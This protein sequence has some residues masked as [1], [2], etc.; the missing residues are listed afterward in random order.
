MWPHPL[1]AASIPLSA[2]TSI[3]PSPPLQLSVAANKAVMVS[4]KTE[5]PSALWR[6]QEQA[7]EFC[8]EG[9]RQLANGE[10]PLATAFYVA[11]SLLCSPMAIKKMV[12]LEKEV[13]ANM[14]ALLE[15]WCQGESPIPKLEGPLDPPPLSVATVAAFLLAFDPHNVTASLFRMEALFKA[16]HPHQVA[17]QCDSLLEVH[18]CVELLLTHAL[19][20]VLSQTH[21]Q[22][23]IAE[24]LQ[25]FVEDRNET[26]TFMSRRQRRYTEKII[27]A[28]LDCLS[29][30]D[31]DPK[32]IL[33][34]KDLCYD[35]LAAI[36]PEDLRVCHIQAKRL[37]ERRMYEECVSLSSRAL[38][39][40]SSSDEETSSLRMLRAAAFFAIGGH[41]SQM[42][43]D[44]MAAFEAHP[45]LA[46][47]SF[48]ALFSPGEAGRV[49]KDS[50]AV[51]EA[52]FSAYREAVRVRNEVRSNGGQELIPPVLRTLQFLI[53]IA[54]GSLRELNVRLADCYLLEGNVP[55][56]LEICNRLLASAEATYRNTLLAQRGLCHLHAKRHAEAL[57]D[58]QAVL[59]DG[60]PHPSSCVKALCGRGLIRAWAGQPYLT[61]LDYLTA[62]GLRFEESGF[63]IKAYVP[64]NQ[65]GFLLLVLQEQVQKMLERK[66]KVRGRSEDRLEKTGWM[67]GL[68]K[69]GDPFGIHQL[70]SLLLELD[71]S[72]EASRL[73]CADALYQLDRLEEAHKILRLAL[74]K[75]SEKSSLLAR[76][77]LFQLRKGRVPDCNQYLKKLI[78][79]GNL[80]CLQAFVKVLKEDDRVLWKSHCHT[81]AVA[82]L[83]NEPGEVYLKEAV[84]YLSLAIPAGGGKAVDSL[85]LRARC[86]GLLGQKKTAIFDF[87][88]VLKED[89]RN[90]RALCGK[91]F[92][93]LALHQKKESTQDLISALQGD[94]ASAMAEICSLKPDTQIQI[95]SW[96][97]EYCKDALMDLGRSQDPL[98]AETLKDL[99]KVGE[100]LV[101]MDNQ[102]NETH[103]LC[104]DLQIARGRPKTALSYLQK[105]FGQS[106]PNDAVN[107]RLGILQA[108]LGNLNGIHILAT[109]A[110]KEHKDLEHLMGFLDANQRLN[111]AQVAAR[112][113]KAML[114]DQCPLGAVKYLTLATLA[115]HNNPQ[116]L[117]Q[118]AA[119]WTQL[120]DYRSALADIQMVVRKHSTNTLKT[121]IGDFC[122]WGHLLLSTSEEEL[123]VKQFI[124]ALQLD[125]PLALSHVLADHRREEV[126][127]A[128]LRTAHTYFAAGHYEEAWTTAKFGLLVDH[129]S[130]GLQKLKARIKRQAS[131]CGIQ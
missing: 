11:G 90:T 128:F 79:T 46:K 126:S 101:E 131:G 53:R 1:P 28:S 96:L 91:A 68:Q 19:A 127:K 112:E 63:V 130:P 74:S 122:S 107:S 105:I 99:S 69:D 100:A 97:L 125:Q 38:E 6:S 109:L 106:E 124:H 3:H 129:N 116:Y 21:S 14:V 5:G 49:E 113:A 87:K 17:T 110:A 103:I 85:L 27:Q 73:L 16:G 7:G 71:S 10:L 95:R 58:F 94:P 37:L 61:A 64:W 23:G 70:A 13:Q 48:E 47:I 115:S 36:A 43:M 84:A 119:C 62:C 117:R 72:D 45:E 120:E 39:A 77:A 26:V 89:P 33:S 111:L 42:L 65:R 40:F 20:L 31:N 102:D 83:Q 55:A 22:D 67:D 93:H 75:D 123:A 8:Q 118:R 30:Q 25:A 18:P 44:L 32:E 35:F 15:S 121:Q 98:A 59:E 50:R 104:V 51:L 54:P 41:V 108:I 4:K 29:L 80:S 78:Q 52:E 81:R 114:K 24:Y 76:L 2:G 34:R 66:E 60:T 12:A 82:V 57:G 88:A 86:Y 9:D 92:I 56:S